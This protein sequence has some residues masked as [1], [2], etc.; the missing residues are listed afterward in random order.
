MHSCYVNI[1]E[2]HERDDNS[3]LTIG[4]RDRVTH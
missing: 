1:S 2:D 3:H 4:T